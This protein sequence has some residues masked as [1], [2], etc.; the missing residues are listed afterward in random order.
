MEMT[1]D[2]EGQDEEEPTAY[3]KLEWAHDPY[4]GF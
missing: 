1:D 4:R 3:D 2:Y